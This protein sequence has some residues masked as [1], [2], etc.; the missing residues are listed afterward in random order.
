MRLD[1]K[2]AVVTGF[3]SEV[4]RAIAVRLAAEGASIV[5]C[6]GSADKSRVGASTGDAGLES[7]VE[8]EGDP[9]RDADARRMVAAAIEH[10]GRVDV[11]VNYGAARRIVGT[12]YDLTDED[13]DEELRVDLKGTI[14]LSR[15]AIPAMAKTGGGSVINLSSVAAPG[16]K[17]RV[18]RSATKAAL[19]SLTVVMALDHGVEGVRVNALLLGPLAPAG[20]RGDPKQQADLAKNTALNQINTVED[21][22]AAV[23]FLASDDAARITG[24]LI[25]LDAG[26][27]L[28]RP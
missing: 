23:A 19:N 10:F 13:F 25:P 8:V 14:V 3:E 5:G 21:V 6:Y 18:I 12:I 20:G 15:A 28:M 16:V 2:V 7:V 27:S 17:G 22:A 26:R 1:G 9:S 4:G 11:L 24:A